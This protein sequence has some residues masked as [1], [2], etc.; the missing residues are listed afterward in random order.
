MT[1]L[2]LCEAASP[3]WERED[4]CYAKGRLLFAGHDVA[5]MATQAAE[6]LYI[7]SNKRV[8]IN[9]ARVLQALAQTGRSHRIYYAMKANRYEPLL[10]KL[11]QS[12]LCGVDICSPNEL[13]LALACGFRVVDMSFTGTAVS[14]RDL[15][16]LLAHPLLTINCDTISMIRRIGERARGRDIGIRINPAIGTGYENRKRLV[17]AGEHATKFGIYKEQWHEALAVAASYNLNITGLHFHTGCGYLG[18]ELPR[19]EASLS[20]ALSFSTNLP[21]LRTINVGGGLGLPYKSTD[22]PLDLSRWASILRR[23]FEGLDVT[24]AVEPGGY[25]VKD[26]GI[27][28]LSVTDVEQKLSTLFT[29]VDGG[30]NL[31]PEPVFYNLPCEP[32]ACIRRDQSLADWRTVTIAGNINEAQDLWTEAFSMP[33]LLE[34]DY[35]AFLNAGAYGAAMSSNHCMRGAFKEIII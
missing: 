10:K 32:V 27:L 17:Y 12:G 31:Q 7:Y 3:W 24:I 11:A 13:D 35:I 20:A 9:I 29:Y 25:L 30:F 1:A 34:G 33:P 2:A 5:D 23:H 14:N 19:W 26:A 16:R 28:V 21:C 22:T 18:T 8:E 4:L 15:D 6:P